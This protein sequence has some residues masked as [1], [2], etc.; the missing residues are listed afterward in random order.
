MSANPHTSGPEAVDAASPAPGTRP[1][2]RWCHPPV[3]LQPIH[4]AAFFDDADGE[5]PPFESA[6]LVHATARRVE[7]HQHLELGR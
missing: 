2:E 1:A 4:V 6:A 3:R 5:L 7:P